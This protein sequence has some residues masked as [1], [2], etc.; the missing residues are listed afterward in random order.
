MSDEPP[1]PEF[2]RPV[3]VDELG[4][5]GRHYDIAANSEERQQLARRLGVL[6]LDRLVAEATLKC[7]P[8]GRFVRMEGRFEADV[9]QTCVVTLEPV[10]A[11][12]EESFTI[13]FDRDLE[14]SR[15]ADVHD[16]DVAFDDE[17]EDVEPLKGAVIDIGEMTAQQLSLALDPYPRREGARLSPAASTDATPEETGKNRPFSN[18]SNMLKGKDRRRG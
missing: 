4:P 1:L 17:M 7:I 12:I 13:V 2:S 15:P 6:A 11:H 16:V 5:G 3:R 9:N 8:G 14:A 10:A 18:L